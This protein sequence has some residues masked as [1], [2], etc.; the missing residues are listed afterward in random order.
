[1][2][3]R[4]LAVLGLVAVSALG[5]AGLASC[6]KKDKD[7]TEPAK[8]VVNNLVV[9]GTKLTVT[10]DGAKDLDLKTLF[11]LT[12]NGSTVEVTDD[13]ITGT[14]Q[15]AEGTYNIKLTYEGQTATSIVTVVKDDGSLVTPSVKTV[16]LTGTNMTVTEDVAKTLDSKSLFKIKLNNA[17]VAVTDAMLTGA[18][19]AKEGTYKVTLTYEGQTATSTVTVVKND[20][21]VASKVLKVTGTKLTV[22]ED[23]VD[24]LDLKSLFAIELNGSA[25]AVTNDMITGTVEAEEG[26]YKVTLSY[27]GQTVESTVEVVKNFVELRAKDQ[28]IEVGNVDS[29]EVRELFSIFEN[30]EPVNVLRSMIDD[31]GLT[32]KAGTYDVVLTYGGK[33]ITC[34]VKV[35]NNYDV[36]I[37]I[38]NDA[39]FAHKNDDNFDLKNVFSLYVGSDEQPITDDM[40]TSEKFDITRAGKYNVQFNFDRFGV[41]YHS[42][43]SVTVLPDVV[44]ETPN[45][46]E[47][48]VAGV[49]NSNAVF[50]FNEVFK[51]YVDGVELPYAEENLDCNIEFVSNLAQ[52]GEYDVTYSVNICGVVTSKTIHY[53]IST[54]NVTMDTTATTTSFNKSKLTESYSVLDFFNI[55][56]NSNNI[57]Y[58]NFFFV[59]A[60]KE[61]ETE[62]PEGKTKVLYTLDNPIEYGTVGTYDVTISFDIDG[63][64]YEKTVAI[65]IKEDVEITEKS[66][67]VTSVLTGV[68]SFDYKTMFNIKKYNPNNSSWNPYDTITVTDEMIDASAVDLNTPGTYEVKCTYEEV[69]YVAQFVVADPVYVGTY[70]AMDDSGKTLEIRNDG[71]TYTG[72]NGAISGTISVTDDVLTI[73]LDN[74]YGSI[75]CKYV[76]GLLTFDWNYSGVLA[77]E[78]AVYAKDPEAWTKKEATNLIKAS[79]GY[80]IT[81]FTNVEDESI[82]HTFVLAYV[83]DEISDEGTAIPND[84]E[85]TYYIDPAVTGTLFEGSATITLGSDKVKFVFDNEGGF[86]LGDATVVEGDGMQGTYTGDHGTLELDG[87][88]K[89]TVTDSED[90]V[91]NYSGVSYTLISGKCILTW[92]DSSYETHRMAIV[93]DKEA[94]TYALDTDVDGFERKYLSSAYCYIDFLGNGIAQAYSVFKY[95]DVWCSYVVDDQT[96]TVTYGD[97]VVA[98][99]MSNGENTM[100]IVDAPEGLYTS[101][102]VYNVAADVAFNHKLTVVNPVFEVPCGGTA[103]ASDVFKMEYTEDGS[104]QE[105]PLQGIV[106]FSGVDFNTVGYYT[107][108]LRYSDDNFDY[109]ASAIVHIYE[110]PF[111]GYAEVGTYRFEYYSNSSYYDSRLE[112]RADGTALYFDYNAKNGTWEI[113]EDGLIYVTCGSYSY[114]VYYENDIIILT[115]VDYGTTKRLYGFKNKTFVKLYSKDDKKLYVVRNSAGVLEYYF[116]DGAEAKGQ[117]NALFAAKELA[118]GV[119][120]QLTNG[121]GEELLEAKISGANSFVYAGPEKGT[122]STAGSSTKLVLDGFGNATLGSNTGTYET[123]K[124]YYKITIGETVTYYEISVEEK[125]YTEVD[126]SVILAGDTKEFAYLVSE[127]TECATLDSTLK[128]VWYKFVAT[129]SGEYAIYSISNPSQNVDNK[130]YLYNESDVQLKYAD[131][132]GEALTTEFGGHKYDFGFKVNLTAGETYYIKVEISTPKSSQYEGYNLNIVAPSAGPEAGPYT[133][134]SDTLTLDGFVGATFGSEEGTYSKTVKDDVT[135]YIVILPSSKK[136]FT[137]DLDNN[138]YTEVDPYDIV[139]GTSKEFAYQVTEGTECATLDSTKTVIWYTF[140]ATTSGTYKIYSISD[141]TSSSTYV[142]NKGYLFAADGTTQLAYNDDKG[143]GFTAAVGGHKYDFG[144]EVELEAGQTYYVRVEISYAKSSQYE[145]YNLNIVAP[146]EE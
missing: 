124:G 47:F 96:V 16:A 105:L 9:T 82:K 130:G 134:D 123:I 81:E 110:V 112:L 118:D 62:V 86:T 33:T 101:N 57:S 115:Y 51:V 146:T 119:V 34:V 60:S 128:T 55:K 18:V 127:G 2:K 11:S 87:A 109:E 121:A 111:A 69:E 58:Y 88:G 14:F 48:E 122:Y 144:F 49:Y 117:V 53:V 97:Q 37:L 23:A 35:V 114:T 145:G 120:V 83:Y 137:L 142:D 28:V 77:S 68:E 100:K 104:I 71:A 29:L 8:E 80:R 113:G 139:G 140:T 64:S 129:I 131:D 102:M 107:V 3:K 67:K 46:D 95:G 75:A 50:K 42:E 4:K 108:T 39:L 7:N 15:A 52:T 66:S 133:G 136:A 94:G 41:S 98:L 20:G 32:D 138:T 126:A 79:D 74:V 10:V 63:K 78:C 21:S 91:P 76:D 141:P 31:G 40:I 73:T 45:G 132:K 93:L 99:E 90:I 1:M 43:A 116:L 19:E 5:T 27:D 84:C 22:T 89:L 13:M 135:Y 103:V 6:G 106:D 54:Y 92:R 26:S 12:Y 72:S 38:N 44:I 85:A 17:D 125:T 65:T 24:T 70:T 143:D 59:D 36:N 25:V 30:G 61:D 56:I